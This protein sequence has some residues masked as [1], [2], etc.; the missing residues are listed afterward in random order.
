MIQ[1]TEISYIGKYIQDQLLS[2][3]IQ[4]NVLHNHPPVNFLVENCE[5]CKINGNSFSVNTDNFT[6]H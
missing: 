1:N 2:K 5:Y 3:C 4:S 6:S